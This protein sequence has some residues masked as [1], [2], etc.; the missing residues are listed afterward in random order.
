MQCYIIIIEHE[1]KASPLNE[2]PSNYCRLLLLFVSLNVFFQNLETV[3]NPIVTKPKPKVEPPKDENKEG[4]K[5]E[6]EATTTKETPAPPETSG[7]SSSSGPTAAGEGEGE[8][9]KMEEDTKPAATEGGEQPTSSKDEDMD[10][11]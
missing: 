4:E 5:K 11:D 3:C 8:G 7:D 9:E 10:L 1:A 2:P 6:G